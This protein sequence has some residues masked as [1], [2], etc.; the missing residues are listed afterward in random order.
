MTDEQEIAPDDST[1]VDAEIPSDESAG[2]EPENELGGM[3]EERAATEGSSEGRRCPIEMGDSKLKC[4]RELHA[5]PDGLDEE[6]VCLMHSKDERKQSWPLFGEFWRLFDQILEEA[7]EGEARF[8]SFVFPEARLSGR[9]FRAIC[10]FNGATFTQNACFYE[11]TFAKAANFFDAKFAQGANFC[12]ATFIGE[13]LLF[14][15]T[16]D[17][18][19]DFIGVEFRDKARFSA[20]TFYRHVN[21]GSASFFSKADFFHARFIGDAKFSRAAFAS[22]VDYGFATFERSI[23]FSSFKF[24][25]KAIFE[26]ATFRREARFEKTEFHKE[27]SWYNSRFLGSAEFRNT[28]FLSPDEAKPSA[29]FALAN[30]SRPREITFDGL[31]LGRVM[32]HLCDISR[33]IFTPSVFWGKRDGNRGLLVFDEVL[34][35]RQEPGEREFPE[36]KPESVAATYQ[37]LKKNYDSR[38]DYGKGNNF[39][40]GE[41][42]MRRLAGPTEGL[43]LGLR[44]WRHRNLSFLNAYRVASDYG[45]NYIRPALLLIASL[46][47]AA[48]LFPIFG[49]DPSRPPNAAS[50]TFAEVSTR[51][52]NVWNKPST[53][54]N[55][56]W[57]EAKLGG[58]SLITSIDTATLQRNPEYAPAYPWGRVIGIV[59]TLLTSTLFGL[60]LL[61]IRRQF[62]R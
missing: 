21:F 62:K 54:S 29:V 40:Y 4:G 30:F 8:A 50:K 9:T 51:Y 36:L 19:A 45:N 14:S 17:Q 42:E 26:G 25:A 32:F 52:S 39:H 7:G 22:D 16:F 38:V 57:T 58:K 1:V 31:D 5:A 35:S 3:V 55:N 24:P 41:M 60:F 44:R 53:W 23:D 11:V 59:E 61:A 6:P 48:A 49:L 34:L 15:A 33:C 43:L 10:L 56:L 27:V 18:S 37:Q 12:F 47:V 13:A 28:K 2:A 20:T 46:V